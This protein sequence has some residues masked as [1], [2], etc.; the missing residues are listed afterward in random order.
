M[1]R[2]SKCGET[3]PLS[4]FFR[5][6]SRKDGFQNWCKTCVK[7]ADKAYKQ[8][9]A[10][11]ASNRRHRWKQQ[12]IQLTTEQHQAMLE[13]QDH[14]C[15]ICGAS[16]ESLAKALHVDHCHDTGAVRGLLCHNCNTGMGKLGDNISTLEKAILYLK[17]EGPL[18]TTTGP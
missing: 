14:S 17:N 13:A 1:K 18:R 8:T 9:E 16:E 3:K 12:G 6:K 7:K 4:E 10:G 2:C 11:K 5:N 15:A